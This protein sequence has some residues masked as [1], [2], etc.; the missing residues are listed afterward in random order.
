MTG[1]IWIVQVV[2]YP[3]FAGVGQDGFAEY[4]T[5]HARLISWVVVPAMFAELG[6]AI[7][8]AFRPEG[9]HFFAYAGLLLVVA[10]WGSTFL[11]QVPLHERLASGFEESTH[12]W[13]VSSNWIRTALWSVRSIL[14]MGWISQ[15]I[16]RSSALHF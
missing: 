8:L 15:C 13:L 2:H 1:V 4:A 11:I 16:G 9:F 7:G 12:R 5:D 6:T 14:V 3:L 10:I